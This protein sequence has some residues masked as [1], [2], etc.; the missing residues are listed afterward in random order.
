[1]IEEKEAETVPEVIKAAAPVYIPAAISFAAS[2]AAIIFGNDAG[3]GIMNGAKSRFFVLGRDSTL[4]SDS[5]ESASSFNTFLTLNFTD[6]AGEGSFYKKGLQVST[7]TYFHNDVAFNNYNLSGVG[8]AS[9]GSVTANSL[10][11]NGVIKCNAT[12]CTDTSDLYLTSGGYSNQYFL[13][14]NKGG[15]LY[16]DNIQLGNSSKPFHSLYCKNA[17]Q[18]TSDGRKKED[19]QYLSDVQPIDDIDNTKLTLADMYDYVKELKLATYKLKDA[20]DNRTELGFI[21]QDVVDT[22][23]GK[24]VVDSSDTDNLVYSLS[25]RITVIEGALQKLIKDVEEMKESMK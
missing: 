21:A 4:N 3:T 9:M 1:M 19:I 6:R 20:R 2:A 11:V 16:G 15:Y 12:V 25:N 7:P 10:S 23:V 14:F 5:T 24:Y 8:S 17:P 18:V 22:K 13:Q